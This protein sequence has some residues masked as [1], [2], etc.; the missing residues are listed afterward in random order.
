M[1]PRGTPPKQAIGLEP[2]GASSRGLRRRRGPAPRS[3]PRHL[4]PAPDRHPRLYCGRGATPRAADDGSDASPQ[5]RT[6]DSIMLTCHLND[7]NPGPF[8]FPSSPRRPP[9]GTIDGG[10][11]SG[12]TAY[13]RTTIWEL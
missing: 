8:P 9:R 4:R 7:W 1:L 10:P 13:R 11:I 6:R 2:G 12:L 5:L 3:S